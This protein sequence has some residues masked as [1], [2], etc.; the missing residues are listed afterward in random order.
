[1]VNVDEANFEGLL[2]QVDSRLRFKLRD[3]FKVDGETLYS[4]YS[5]LHIYSMYIPANCS[6]FPNNSNSNIQTTPSK[7]TLN[8]Q[9]HIPLEHRSEYRQISISQ[10]HQEIEIINEDRDAESSDIS[11]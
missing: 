5:L 4:I 1:M 10:P 11:Y 8:I 7:A 2:A 6:I 3:M 9:S